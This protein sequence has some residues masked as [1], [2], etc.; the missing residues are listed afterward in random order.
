M[1]TETKFNSNEQE[2]NLL[3]RVEIRID[4]MSDLGGA[5]VTK[6]YTNKNVETMTLSYEVGCGNDWAYKDYIREML[7]R[8]DIQVIIVI[9]T[10]IKR[11][12]RVYSNIRYKAK[13][14]HSNIDIMICDA[15][16][17]YINDIIRIIGNPYL[18]E[19]N[20]CINGR[21]IVIPRL[22]LE[23][24]ANRINE[25]RLEFNMMSIDTLDI[26][27]L[28]SSNKLGVVWLAYG[29]IKRLEAGIKAEQDV[30]IYMKQGFNVSEY[31]DVSNR[32]YTQGLVN[33]ARDAER[34]QLVRANNMRF[35]DLKEVEMFIELYDAELI[36]M[37]NINVK[38]SYADEKTGKI[39]VKARGDRKSEYRVVMTDSK[40]L[41]ILRKIYKEDIVEMELADLEMMKHREERLGTSSLYKG[42]LVAVMDEEV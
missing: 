8:T 12:V 37:K 31:M 39:H 23:E 17:I 25:I 24:T 10:D 26:N 3:K 27:G 19:I 9:R 28:L 13:H 15:D 2:E 16:L 40:S 20:K 38:N 6:T 14:G 11:Y 5:S 30:G 36:E 41:G 7:A 35:S 33:R 21:N 34:T 32:E 29:S 4:K 22:E 42:K 18:I 1:N